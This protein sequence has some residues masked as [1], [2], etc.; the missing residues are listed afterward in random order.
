[1]TW[2]CGIVRPVPGL[3]FSPVS[4]FADA[5][6]DLPVWEYA[7][8]V[9][10]T[11]H[12]LQAIGQLY[13]DRADCENGFDE[14]KNQWGWGGYTTHDLERCNLSACAVVLIYNGW[15]GYVRLA[16]PKARL[17]AITSRPLLL[18]GVARL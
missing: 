11:H 5:P 1:M 4:L 3:A 13:R 7:V 9:T 10:N 18:A 6:D 2:E 15:S 8:L 17:E 12:T 16:H 14:L